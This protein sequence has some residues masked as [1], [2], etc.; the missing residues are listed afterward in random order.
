MKWIKWGLMYAGL[1]GAIFWTPSIALH[2]TRGF[3]FKG[4]DV[5]IL[6]FLLPL[7]TLGCFAILW[8]LSGQEKSRAFIARSMLLGIWVLGPLFLTIS[9]SFAGGGFAKPEGWKL[10][11]IG[12]LLFPIF[13]FSMSTYDGTLFAILAAT[14]LL[15]LI[16]EGLHLEFLRLLRVADR[17]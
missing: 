2:A 1:A 17:N 13:T 4:L 3:N 16:S 11:A 6:T 8:R 12:T 5:L 15:I 9:A 7:I 14:L 10:V